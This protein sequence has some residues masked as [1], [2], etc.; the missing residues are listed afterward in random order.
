MPHTRPSP[1][2]SGAF[3]IDEILALGYFVGFR[4]QTLITAVAIA[5]AESGLRRYAKGHNP[6]TAG[7][8]L[9]SFDRGLWQINDCYHP[10]VSDTCAYDPL[11]N[12]QHAYIISNHG[13]SF[14]PWSTYNNGAYKGNV[15]AVSA[16]YNAGA[17]QP[18]VQSWGGIY[19]PPTPTPNPQGPEPWDWSKKVVTSANDLIQH[20]KGTRSALDAVT[21]L[22]R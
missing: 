2:S 12:A 5:K 14:H 6:P 13:Q 21:D 19:S 11:C 4:G 10:E 7:C 22:L 15:P 17:W 9:G 3:S 18:I 1:N 16:R 8:P 20:E